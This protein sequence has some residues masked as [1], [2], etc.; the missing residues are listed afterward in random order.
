M[1]VEAFTGDE[2]VKDI[3]EGAHA[4]GVKVVASNHDFDKTPDKDDIV[5]RLVKMQ[6]L[7]ADIPKIAVMPQCKRMYLHF[8]KQHVKWQKNMQTVRSLQ[9]L[10]QVPD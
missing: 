5:G 4:H 10:W 3:I 2:V 9:C 7:G 8:L 1:D 6:E